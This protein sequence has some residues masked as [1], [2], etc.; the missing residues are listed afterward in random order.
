MW[1]L[2]VL[3]GVIGFIIGTVAFYIAYRT[4]AYMA[5]MM[6]DLY[7]FAFGK[8]AASTFFHLIPIT[9]LIAVM[10][11]KYVLYIAVSPFMSSL[12]K[13][14]EELHLKEDYVPREKRSLSLIK[15]T[16]LIAL[17]S[18]YKEILWT[19]L[20]S[21]AGILVPV[22][23][24]IGLI[25]TQSYYIGSAHLDYTLARKMSYSDMRKWIGTNRGL[26]LG[27]G[28]MYFTILLI[29]FL[30]LLIAPVITTAAGTLSVVDTMRLAGEYK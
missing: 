21:L 3:T 16:G 24:V 20:F 25:I 30:G 15:R 14:I 26:A 17:R 13:K 7:P 19:I 29:P 28:A 6:S 23:G 18:L 22:A 4:G 9:Y 10:L 27:N 5:D 1:A 8:R 12:S 11:V 2:L